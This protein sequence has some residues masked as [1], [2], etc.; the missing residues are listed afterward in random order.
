MKVKEVYIILISAVLLLSAILLFLPPSTT[1]QQIQSA[2][3]VDGPTDTTHYWTDEAVWTAAD[4]DINSYALSGSGTEIDPYLIQSE[5]DLAYLSWTIY[6]DNPID[7]QVSGTGLTNYFYSGLYFTQTVDLDLSAYYWQPIGTYYINAVIR[8]FSGNY[9]GDDHTI[10][11]VFTPEDNGSGFISYQ[12]LFGYVSG[13]ET[14]QRA[15]LS[16][17][18]VIDSYVQGTSHVGGVVA[19]ADSNSN[20]T[21]CFNAGQVSGQGSAGGVVGRM[22]QNSSIINCSN[23]GLIEGIGGNAGGVV[24]YAYSN[25]NITNCF[26]AGQVSGQGSTG[27]VVGRMEQNSSIINCS[28]TGSVS[29]D[30]YVAGLVGYCGSNSSITGSFNSGTVTGSSQT[31]G[32]VGYGTSSLTITD[33]YNTGA[34]DCANNSSGGIVGQFSASSVINC[35]NTGS[36]EG[37]NSV[38]GIL[39][40]G[41]VNS[42]IT[43]SYNTGWII[44]EIAVGGIGGSNS[45]VSITNCYNTGSI[46]GSVSDTGGIAG[47]CDSDSAITDCY[48]IGS[49]SGEM[50]VGG[51]VGG[52]FAGAVSNSGF[53]GDIEGTEYVG[54]I[55]GEVAENSS[56]TDCYA[57]ANS[58]SS[59]SLIGTNSGAI[60]NI[61]GIVSAGGVEN[62]MY[63]GDNF[64]EFA[65]FNFDG[66]PIPQNLTWSG[67]FQEPPIEYAGSSDWILEKMVD[68]GWQMIAF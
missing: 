47:Y 21:N 9:D 33:C 19:Y 41:S 18:G 45:S 1:N 43:N 65:W 42:T 10:K 59:I 20:I 64:T 23:S 3:A 68:D 46:E 67:Q 55:C 31:G 17:L 26:N 30:D 8:Y 50:Y 51:I 40:S 37:S 12:G 29:G 7:S 49:V 58:S 35:Y 34:I 14:T 32:V 4:K 39:G 28:N 52:C 44:G 60:E 25:S 5:W 54:A 56:A 6:S 57:V 61:V 53:E 62:K 24:G 36:V 15:T 66:S 13:Q 48:N 2:I 27:G 11:G 16:N 63:F 22:G 38:G